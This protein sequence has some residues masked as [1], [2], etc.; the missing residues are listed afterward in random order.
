MIVDTPPAPTNLKLMTQ[1]HSRKKFKISLTWN[2]NQNADSYV[3]SVNSTT[4]VSV[5]NTT[6]FIMTG[7]YNTL[8]IFTV[9]AVN[10]AG[11]SEG[12]TVNFTIGMT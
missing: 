9:T 8:Y 4:N 3:V 6:T 11:Y 2:V 7:E 5:E 12:A 1:S 10:C